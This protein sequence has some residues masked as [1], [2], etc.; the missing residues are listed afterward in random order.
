MFPARFLRRR[1]VLAVIFFFSLGYFINSTFNQADPIGV[2]SDRFEDLP[3]T[4]LQ[5]Q[6]RSRVEVIDKNNSWSCLNSKQGH[7]LVV[8]NRGF[9]CPRKAVLVN[10]CCDPESES[11]VLYSCSSCRDD[12]NCCSIYEDCVS[13]CM[14]PEKESLLQGVLGKASNTL[15]LLLK[16]VRNHYELCLAKCRTSSESVQHENTYRDPIAKHCYGQSPPKL[17]PPG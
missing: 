5:L 14:H 9:V 2:I 15:K 8:D 6:L 17:Q 10:N 12:T 3:H 11:S 1:W 13:C 4:T 7:T 16:G